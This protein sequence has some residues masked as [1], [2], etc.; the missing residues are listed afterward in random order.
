MDGTST[1]PRPVLVQEGG[2]RRA[3][4]RQVVV[5]SGSLQPHQSGVGGTGRT[6]CENYV[7]C[8]LW[9]DQAG[10]VGESTFIRWALRQRYPHRL[11]RL[12][13]VPQERSLS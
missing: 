3:I 6:G 9:Q 8:I 10:H 1:R 4:Q 2:K 12:P 11:E 5:E 7:I 13:Q